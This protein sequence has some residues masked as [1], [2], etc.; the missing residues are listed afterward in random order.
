MPTR[1]LYLTDNPTLGGTIRILQSWL[2]LGREQGTLSGDVAI[3]PGSDFH[4]WLDTHEIPYV[5]NPQP[6]P[7]KWWPVPAPWRWGITTR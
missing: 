3:R 7:M 1:V 4:Q 5:T 2:I 6:W